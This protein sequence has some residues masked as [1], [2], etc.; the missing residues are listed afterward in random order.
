MPA[1]RSRSG[2][3]RRPLRGGVRGSRARLRRAARGTFHRA[4]AAGSGSR[5]GRTCRRRGRPAGC[6][7]S[8]F[9]PSRRPPSRRAGGGGIVVS[10]SRI[11]PTRREV[12]AKRGLERAGD[13]VLGVRVVTQVV[14]DRVDRLLVAVERIEA[15][16]AAVVEPVRKHLLAACGGGAR[17]I[18]RREGGDRTE[19]EHDA[20]DERAKERCGCHER[21]LMGSGRKP[22]A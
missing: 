14:G 1:G 11:A 20:H 17:G 15:V 4:R 6:R 16:D 7:S 9:R 22:W 8:P 18:C 5:T 2:C 21:D 13:D 10:R 3:L 19:D 12:A